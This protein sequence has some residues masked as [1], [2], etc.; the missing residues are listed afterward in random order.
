MSTDMLGGSVHS[1]ELVS[2]AQELFKPLSAEMVKELQSVSEITVEEPTIEEEP[3][4]MELSLARSFE[5]S[6]TVD[7]EGIQCKA[8]TG[9]TITTDTV[10]VDIDSLMDIYYSDIEYPE[11]DIKQKINTLSVLW[12]FLVNQQ[13]VS[14]ENAAGILGNIYVEGNFGEQQ[15]T[16]LHISNISQARTLLGSG[17]YGYGCCQWT[18]SK[19]QK[20]LL[21]YYEIANELFDDWSA[22]KI[23][24]ECSMIL[25]ESKALG[26]FD[27]IY[28]PTTIEDATGSFA[29][30][31][32]GY[33]NSSNQ[34]SQKDGMYYLTSQ[35]GSGVERLNYA[36][37]IY[38]YF[39]E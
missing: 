36:Y 28:T 33:S 20:D 3:E 18:Y 13:G 4:I 21:K 24:A 16:G 27:D 8:S 23:A 31:F 30:I 38:N 12:D 11:W 1:F 26:V 17:S 19:R 6:N 7:I 22:V 15:G 34:W 5:T 14:A 35:K 2:K 39:M 32:E 9:E 29:I 25:E 10:T 37:S